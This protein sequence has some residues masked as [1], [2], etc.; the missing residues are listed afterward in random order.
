VALQEFTV[1][2]GTSSGSTIGPMLSANLGIRTVDL[3]IT[4]WAMHSI[5]ETCSVEDIDSMLRICQG[6]YRY[7][8]EVDNSFIEA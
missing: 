4:Q 7:F 1:K 8:V 6:F 5:R 2:N 3:G